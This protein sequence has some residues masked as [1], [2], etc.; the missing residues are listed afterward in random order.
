MIGIQDYLKMADVRRCSGIKLLRSYDLMRHSF[1]VAMLF[2]H[3]ASLEKIQYTADVL[4]I[5]L[6][7]DLLEVKTGDLLEP[8]KSFSKRTRSAWNTIEKQIMGGNE[9]FEEFS[10]Q[11]IK[12]T[13]TEQQHDLFKCC[14]CLEL[15]IFIV[16]EMKL[17]NRTEDVNRI[18]RLVGSDILAFG[19]QSIIEFV[20]G[21]ADY[22]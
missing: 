8:V 3:F 1:M 19:F 18:F 14:D 11:H 7:H 13:L 16:E 6:K 21:F 5:V 10:D 9:G 2:Q 20:N 22:K 17:G 12:D 15:W 4:N